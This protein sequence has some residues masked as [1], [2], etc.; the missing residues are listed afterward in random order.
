MA[1]ELAQTVRN[2][3]VPTIEKASDE[4]VDKVCKTYG[5]TKAQLP[6]IKLTDA[7][8]AGIAVGQGDVVKIDRKSWQTGE[9][10]QYFRL[11]VE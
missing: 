7:G 4:E 10:T 11:V 2:Y 3:L 6:H 9:H 5:I 8:L 1:T